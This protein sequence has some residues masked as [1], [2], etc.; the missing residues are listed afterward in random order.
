MRRLFLGAQ[1]VILF[2][3]GIGAAILAVMN[4]TRDGNTDYVVFMVF[5]IISA[6]M[7]YASKAVWKELD[8]E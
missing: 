4:M 3:A 2:A 5:G 1:A 7:F 8:Y 6:T